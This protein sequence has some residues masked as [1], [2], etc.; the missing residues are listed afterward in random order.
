MNEFC[1]HRTYKNKSFMRQ[2]TLISFL[3]FF[4]VFP[5]LS[6][7]YSTGTG[8]PD[9][10][11][12]KNLVSS[13]FIRFDKASIPNNDIYLYTNQISGY[14]RDDGA[15]WGRNT[16]QC[17]SNTDSTNGSCPTAP[18][19]SSS[20]PINVPLTF[21]DATSKISYKLN[22]NISRNAST[23]STNNQMGPNNPYWG[24][25]YGARFSASISNSEVRKIINPGRYTAQLRMNLYRNTSNTTTVNAEKLSDWIS[26]ITI[27][28]TD[29]Y[30][31]QIYFP[32]FP[33]SDPVID[34]NLSHRP[35]ATSG[36]NT[37]GFSSLDVCLY[38]GSNST[39]NLVNL[40]FLDDG[41]SAPGR[42]SSFFSVYKD[43]SDKSLVGNRIDYKVNILNPTT[44]ISEAV[45]NGTEITW[46]NTN[47][48]KSQRQVIIPGKSGVSLCVPAPI[49]LVTPVFR[50]A[51]KSSGRFHGV[52]RI[53]YTPSTQTGKLEKY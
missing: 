26:N 6:E 20:T 19:P 43:G 36:V 29:L 13:D 48:R 40:T 44:G 23:G 22:V 24:G 38:D 10:L 50:L 32:E 17:T 18:D 11:A 33:H 15:K 4:L 1:L 51:D 30:N 42:D 41:I 2:V 9:S 47:S 27:E 35:G 28:V 16:L 8:S 39:S 7:D 52:L 37:T 31:H 3:S 21:T 14:D 46:K 5:A 25:S 45:S 12:P 34:L 49:T 53:I